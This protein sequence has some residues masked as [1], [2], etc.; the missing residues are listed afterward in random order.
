MLI[1]SIRYTKYESDLFL[2]AKNLKNGRLKP[3]F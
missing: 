3:F 1:N 2:Y